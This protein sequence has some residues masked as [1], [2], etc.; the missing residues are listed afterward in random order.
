MLQAIGEQGYDA[1]SRR[2]AND[3]A[4][5][6]GLFR[7]CLLGA[8]SAHD[9]SESGTAGALDTLIGNFRLQRCD[10]PILQIIGEL[11][12]IGSVVDKRSKFSVVTKMRHGDVEIDSA[13]AVWMTRDQRSFGDGHEADCYPLPPSFSQVIFDHGFEVGLAGLVNGGVADQFSTSRNYFRREG[14]RLET[15]PFFAFGEAAMDGNRDSTPEVQRAFRKKASPCV[16][17]GDNE[18]TLVSEIFDLSLGLGDIGH[19][20]PSSIQLLKNCELT[21]HFISP[22]STPLHSIR[23]IAGTA[24]PRR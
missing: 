20:L 10:D 17:V 11:I 5:H 4:A 19:L 2:D 24:F 3:S 7:L 1:G 21:A 18:R 14:V 6:F 9:C 15:Q 16:E 22:T 13:I 8:R 23:F 12:D